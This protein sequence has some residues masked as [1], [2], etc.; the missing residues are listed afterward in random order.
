VSLAIGH[1]PSPWAAARTL[2]NL[3]NPESRIAAAVAALTWIK[4]YWFSHVAVVIALGTVQLHLCFV[5][6]IHDS[7]LPG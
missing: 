4:I 6:G 5:L 2:L 3:S 7:V 1:L